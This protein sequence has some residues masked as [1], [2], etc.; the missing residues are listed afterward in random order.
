[1]KALLVLTMTWISFASAAE[2]IGQI[3]CYT[4]DRPVSYM[5]NADII[6]NKSAIGWR[7]EYV[8]INLTSYDW[9]SH[10]ETA[11]LRIWKMVPN[12]NDRNF[13]EHFKNK[14]VE[15]DAFYDDV[16]A[17]SSIIFEGKEHQ[18]VCDIDLK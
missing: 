9:N 18:L 4:L 5:I 11:P 6:G 13:S 2:K 10:S 8:N 3:D 7:A 12:M 15:L 1:M 16:G 17:M 14:E